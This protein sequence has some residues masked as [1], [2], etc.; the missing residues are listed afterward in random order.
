MLK[1]L[2]AVA[3]IAITLGAVFSTTTAQAGTC[4]GYYSNGNGDIVPC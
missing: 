3:L 2:F 1:K 4:Y